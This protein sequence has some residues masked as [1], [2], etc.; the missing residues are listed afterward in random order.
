MKFQEWYV[1]C[2]G[3][4]PKMVFGGPRAKADAAAHLVCDTHLT[5]TEQTKVKA[6]LEG[7]V[8]LGERLLIVAYTTG[9]YK[10]PDKS[11]VRVLGPQ[12][13]D[14]AKTEKTETAP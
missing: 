4:T 13:A 6:F 5:P 11:L 7:E 14:E 8:K 1:Y 2:E 3:K 9:E 12:S 10:H